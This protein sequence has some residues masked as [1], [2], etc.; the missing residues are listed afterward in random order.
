M[1]LC[2]DSEDVQLINNLKKN[3]QEGFE[4]IYNKFYS[5]LLYFV[6]GYV[7]SIEVAEEILTD[8]FL[9]V[10]NRKND[11]NSLDNLRA[12]LY[13]SAKNASL[14]SLRAI[15]NKPQ[16]EPISQFEEMLSN[17]RTVFNKII[18]LELVELVLKEV[19]LLP[20]KQKDVFN[21]SFIEDK[22][23]EEIAEE[24]NMSISAVYTNRSRAISTLKLS[25]QSNNTVLFTFL[26]LLIKG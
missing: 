17:D 1:Q 3:S 24:L 4:V 2:G 22:T 6:L 9:V 19:S 5:P 10:W 13:I 14:N 26:T 18:E 16:M 21:L 15:K 11:F 20:N 12:F 8:V 7:K 23:V 25:F